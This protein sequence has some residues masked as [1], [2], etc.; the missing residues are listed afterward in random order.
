MDEVYTMA[1]LTGCLINAVESAQRQSPQ[2]LDESEF[3]GVVLCYY[4]IEVCGYS[5][6]ITGHQ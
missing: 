3:C 2:L 1:W 4:S 5:C 6:K